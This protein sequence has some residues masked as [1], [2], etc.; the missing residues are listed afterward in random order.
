MIAVMIT[1]RKSNK[2]LLQRRAGACPSS[3]KINTLYLSVSMAQ[4]DS[5]TGVRTSNLARQSKVVSIYAMKILWGM[6]M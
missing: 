6:E 1:F 2:N 4:H 3:R 5:C